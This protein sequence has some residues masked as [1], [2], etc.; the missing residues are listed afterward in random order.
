MGLLFCDGTGLPPARRH[1]LQIVLSLQVVVGLLEQDLVCGQFAEGNTQATQ[2]PWG[3]SHSRE[4]FLG[5]RG[6]T[7]LK[8]S[9]FIFL[10]FN[11]FG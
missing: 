3:N 11:S 7:H 10:K 2:R 6:L 1:V 8:I 9:I 5:F 4:N